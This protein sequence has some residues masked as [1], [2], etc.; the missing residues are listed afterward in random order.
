MNVFDEMIE[1]KIKPN[2]HTY[3]AI[4]KTIT[5]SQSIDKT[6][7]AN[8]LYKIMMNDSNINM[9]DDITMVT[10]IM[11]MFGSVSDTKNMNDIWD[12]FMENQPEITD[13]VAC[14][15]VMRIYFASSEFERVLK[16][17]D[18]MLKQKHKIT[19]NIH[20][21]RLCI[22]ACSMLRDI[23]KGM[24]LHT[25]CM[26]FN[27]HKGSHLDC[28]TNDKLIDMYIKCTGD[29]CNGINK[30]RDKNG[31][32]DNNFVYRMMISKFIEHGEYLMAFRIFDNMNV[33]P[34]EQTFLAILKACD[35]K[36]LVDEMCQYMQEIGINKSTAIDSAIMLAYKKCS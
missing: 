27:R 21:Y 26:N 24:E 4:A 7:K 34:T 1:Q 5:H 33:K 17:Y 6:N 28:I 25:T 10:S 14:N 3:K 13:L 36:R 29:L 15:L 18:C 9:Y 12:H 16:V 20:T 32:S 11:A 30:W 22:E 2:I 19:A 8:K 31:I 35:D 23:D